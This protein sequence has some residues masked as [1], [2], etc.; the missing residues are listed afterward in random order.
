MAWQLLREMAE[1][2]EREAKEQLLQARYRLRHRQV[3][4]LFRARRERVEQ[5]RRDQEVA[6][7]LARRD[8]LVTLTQGLRVYM[9]VESADTLGGMSFTAEELRNPDPH[10][11]DQVQ[12]VTFATQGTV[13]ASACR[14]LLRMWQRV[15]SKE[16]GE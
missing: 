1:K 5:R 2:Q 8:F 9:L 3:T 16:G 14:Q 15:L 13:V 6:A 12:A 11:I 7:M 4:L 10:L